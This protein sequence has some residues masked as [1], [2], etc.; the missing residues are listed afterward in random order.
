MVFC[1]V[2]TIELIF[3]SYIINAMMHCVCVGFQ[4]ILEIINNYSRQENYKAGLKL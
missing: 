2:L 3:S 4:T 1:L